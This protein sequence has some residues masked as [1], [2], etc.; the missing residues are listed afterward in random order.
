MIASSHRKERE[1]N[2]ALFLGVLP[3]PENR[4]TMDLYSSNNIPLKI[5]NNNTRKGPVSKAHWPSMNGNIHHF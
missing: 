1:Q 4:K 2:R 3:L 5:N